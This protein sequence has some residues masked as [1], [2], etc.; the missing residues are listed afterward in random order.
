MVMN[1]AKPRSVGDARRRRASPSGAPSSAAVIASS[2]GLH[3]REVGR[4]G[5]EPVDRRQ[6][7]HRVARSRAATRRSRPRCRRARGPT[8]RRPRR[9]CGLMSSLDL[10]PHAASATRSQIRMA[11]VLAQMTPARPRAMHLRWPCRTSS[12]PSPRAERPRERRR[13][14]VLWRLTALLRPHRARFVL[15][16]GD[17]ARARRRSRSSYPQA[18][19][20]A[21]DVGHELARTTDDLDLIVRAGCSACSCST[22]CS[23]GCATTASAG[24]ASASSPICAAWSSIAIAH[25]AARRGSTS[26]AAAS[27]SAGSRRTSR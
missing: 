15:A 27:S 8:A 17:A 16:V 11:R 10:L 12:L 7:P 13:L 26:G 4:C 20:Y 22:R 3:R 2:C 21:I 23:C 5:R 25:A 24:S 9:P 19:R 1:I 14:A 18:A 6:R